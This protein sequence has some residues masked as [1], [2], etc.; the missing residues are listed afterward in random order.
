MGGPWRKGLANKFASLRP[1]DAAYFADRYKDFAARLAQAEKG[2]DQ[3]MAPYQG[4]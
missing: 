3:K 2:W 1:D 4:P